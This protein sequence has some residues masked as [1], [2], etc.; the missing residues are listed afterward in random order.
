LGYQLPGRFTGLAACIID[1]LDDLCLVSYREGKVL[2]AV[3]APAPQNLT[4]A[5]HQI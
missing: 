3:V 2:V 5:A 1:D 4:V